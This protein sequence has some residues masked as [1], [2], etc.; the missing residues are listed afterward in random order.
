MIEKL[1]RLVGAGRLR[2]TLLGSIARVVALGSQFLVL[3]IM[4]KILPKAEFGDA[5]IVFT[6]YRLASLGLG[7]GLGSVVIYH[8]S[9]RVDES[10]LDARIMR[11]TTVLAFFLS[12][13][14][15]FCSV[16]YSN[17]ICDWFQKPGMSV[18]LVNMAPLIPFGTLL[19]LT[20]SSLDA[21]R[22]V[23]RSIA[24]TELAP[25][26]LRLILLCLVAALSLPK[27][28]V[29]SALW[30]ALALP[31]ATS[32]YSLLITIKDGFERLTFWDFKYATWSAV[33]PIAGQQ[34]QGLDMIIVGSLF[35][36]SQAADYTIASRLASFFP[37]LQQIVARTFVPE[38]GSLIHSGQIEKLNS[39]LS[40]FRT[41]SVLMIG[42]LTSLIL[43]VAPVF[44]GL[45]GDYHGAL[46]ILVALAIAPLIR[47]LFVGVD[48]V[49][50]MQGRA[51]YAAIISVSSAFVVV[52]MSF[53]L[54]EKL[55]IF[56]IP[57][58]MFASAVSINTAAALLIKRTGIQVY[59]LNHAPGISLVTMIMVLSILTLGGQNAALASAA[60]LAGLSGILAFEKY[61]R[62]WGNQ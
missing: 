30:I 1:F 35:T 42:A 55:G 41:E 10:R 27:S 53:A 61:D 58:A 60:G 7:G 18:W 21:R 54:H 13:L 43:F 2:V 6:I 3:L 4:G 39:R 15:A 48:V 46:S 62:R 47:S 28:A 24:V 33:Y 9:R 31:W 19:Q 17:L 44:T 51:G 26:V 59:G 12:T 49:L 40:E 32:T 23:A 20:A 29:A 22:L 50:R 37:F 11:S 34:L 25:N 14:L 16:R 8:V 45:M 57:F 56:A 36:S 52:V 5:M 38:C